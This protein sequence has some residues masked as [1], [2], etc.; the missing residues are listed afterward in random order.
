MTVLA[1]SEVSLPFREEALMTR[2]H[3]L[4]RERERLHQ[5]L[6]SRKAELDEAWREVDE[7]RASNARLLLVIQRRAAP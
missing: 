3:E 5:E 6:L 4:A 7:L 1:L 2:V